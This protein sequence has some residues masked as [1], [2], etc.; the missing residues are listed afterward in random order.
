MQ[1]LRSSK[2]SLNFSMK[3]INEKNRNSYVDSYDP[4]LIG[5]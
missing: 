4:D 2:G 5:S 1:D 3:N